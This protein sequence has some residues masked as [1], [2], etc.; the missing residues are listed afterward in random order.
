MENCPI[1]SIIDHTYHSS[2]SSANGVSGLTTRH[3]T[4]SLVHFGQIDL[5]RSVVL[6][7]DDPVGGRTDGTVNDI[8]YNPLWLTTCAVCT[9]QHTLLGRSALST[10]NLKTI[11]STKYNK[12]CEQW[13][14]K[15]S[16]NSDECE[17]NEWRPHDQTLILIWHVN[18]VWQQFLSLFWHGFC[19]FE[20]YVRIGGIVDLMNG[21][22]YLYS[23]DALQE[24]SR[25]RPHLTI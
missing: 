16:V 11:V 19:V 15:G 21:W 13:V 12:R 1:N 18:D 17:D 25:G 8:D 5:N 22:L 3:P 23:F 7:M 14:G 4:S 20:S 2:K 10:Y 9:G 6:G 24:L